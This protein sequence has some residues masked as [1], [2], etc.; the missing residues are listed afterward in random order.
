LTIPI[1]LT[2]LLL[3]GATDVSVNVALL[4]LLGYAKSIQI[5]QAISIRI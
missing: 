4:G 5:T 3:E 1:I 2:P